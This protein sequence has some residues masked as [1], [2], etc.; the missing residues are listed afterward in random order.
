MILPTARIPIRPLR[1]D[2]LYAPAYSFDAS[3]VLYLGKIVFG[4]V[5]LQSPSRTSCRLAHRTNRLWTGRAF[6]AA[7]IIAIHEGSP[8]DIPLIDSTGI[9]AFIALEIGAVRAEHLIVAAD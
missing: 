4:V 9:L 3:A 1:F 2:V 7:R 6:Y 8:E 5:K